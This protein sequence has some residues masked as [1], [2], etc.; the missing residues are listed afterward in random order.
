MIAIPP[1]TPLP[2]TDIFAEWEEG[3]IER[4]NAY[5]IDLFDNRPKGVR[6]FPKEAQGI[7]K[8]F[9]EWARLMD[10]RP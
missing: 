3:T 8:D 10:H 5:I 7:A 4:Y 2:E 9:V 1:N 6:K